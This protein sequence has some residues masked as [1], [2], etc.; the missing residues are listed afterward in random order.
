MR[1]FFLLKR[2]RGVP[3]VAAA[4]AGRQFAFRKF[5]GFCLKRDLFF[6]I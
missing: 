3:F 1:H 2:R 5:G 4:E 6:A